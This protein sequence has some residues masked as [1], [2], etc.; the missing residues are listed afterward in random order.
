MGIS[1]SDRY[2]LLLKINDIAVTA[3]TPAKVFHEVCT[4]LNEV[5]PYDRAGLSLYDPNHDSL[6]IAEIF[7]PHE[8]SIFA[9]GQQLSRTNSQ[10][11]WVFENKATLFRRD[12]EKDSRFPGDKKVIEEGYRS[13]CSVPL[14]IRG[15]CVGVI[16]VLGSHKNQLSHDH[17]GILEESSK[18]IALA[19]G[20]LMLTCPTHPGTS[21]ICPRCIGASGGKATVKK[22]RE[23]LSNWGKKGG[24]GRKNV[25]FP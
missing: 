7:G 11:G 6:R 8:N 25:D 23:H 5:V 4:V 15:N 18:P 24:R 22:H 2:G 17:A 3:P 13:I 16:S 1:L 12:L 21:L 9:V 10:T 20:S 14:V 19:I